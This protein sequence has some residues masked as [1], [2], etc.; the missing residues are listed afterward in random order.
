MRRLD[1]AVVFE[2]LA[3]VDPSTSAFISI[4][5]MAT[6]LIAAY[7]GEAVR[8]HWGPL[9][10]SGEKLASYCLTEPGAGSDAGSLKTRAVREGDE[11]VLDGSKA[12]ISGAGATD[13]LVVMA[14][15]GEARGIS[16]FVVPADAP[17][18]SYG[19][20]EEK[21]G[22]NSQPTRAVTFE[23][24]ASPPATCWAT[25][26]KA[27]HR[28]EGL[29]GGRIN[30][31]T[32][33][34]GA[35][36]G[37]LD[38]ARRYMGERRQ[39]GKKLADFQALQ[40]KLADMATNW[41]PR[42]RWCTPPRASSTPM[43]PTRPCGARW[44]S[45]SPPM[46]A[47]PSATR[48]CRST[49]ATATSANTRWSGCCATRACTD[50]GRHQRDHAGHRRPPPARRRRRIAMNA[51]TTLDHGTTDKKPAEQHARLVP[52]R[53]EVEAERDTSP[54][55]PSTTRPRIPGPCTAWPPCATWCAL[56]ADRECGAGHHRQR[57]KFFCAGADLKQFAD[58]D[59][60]VAHEAARR[61]GEAF[62]ALSGFRGVS[63]AAINGYAMGGGLEVALACDLRIAEQHAQLALPEASVGLLP[64][65]GGTQNLTRLAG[66]GWAKR[67][68]LL[69]ERI[70]AATALRIG[71]VEDVVA[72]G[73]SLARA[74]AWAKQAGKQS[75]AS[76]AASK[77]LVQ[78]TRWQPHASAL[79]AEREAFVD[80][81]DGPTSAKVSPPSSK[82]AHRNG[83]THEPRRRT[84]THRRCCSKN[85]PRPGHCAS[86]SP[87][88]TRRARST[89]S[90][91]RW[92]TCSTTAC[93]PGRRPGHRRG[94][95][96]GR[97]R[98]GVLRRRRPARAV[99]RHGRVPPGRQTDIRDNTYAPSSSR[100]NT[101][102]ITAST[103][104][105]SRSCA[106][107]TAS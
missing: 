7:A 43:R 74:L 68:I 17:G 56:D 107:A 98:K 99:P 59:K 53:L 15:T 14:R 77:K 47:L 93:A 66:E 63:I 105:P 18:I 106:G 81:F 48:R 67:M 50:P 11:Y 28:D 100:W 37:A 1:A 40:F 92:R 21:M 42:G 95:P 78:A 36:Q 35:A 96:A 12:F 82:N 87:R 58:G 24:C 103:P 30:I 10:T 64:C 102:S 31:A 65:A 90:R 2:E 80:L 89:A 33:S 20:K 76:V 4:H 61:F 45:A 49:A 88:S 104:V 79:V 27:S 16:A 71:V 22:W 91:W 3:T 73:E 46:P 25:K 94:G 6:W 44:P 86:A 83:P 84:R 26:A 101:A 69:G 34:L 97:R 75:P 85:V 60:A 54:S 19:R 62:E 41:W 9:L 23:T 8:A 13:V 38:A 72:S 5:N 51:A 29:D 55:S 39:F 70:D 32:C 52:P 57:E